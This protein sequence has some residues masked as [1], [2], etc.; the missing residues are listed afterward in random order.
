MGESTALLIP[1]EGQIVRDPISKDPL[2]VAG[3]VKPLIG[4][5]GRYWRR[6]L[7]DGSV[8]IAQPRVAKK[9]RE[10]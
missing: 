6:R 9:T 2:P 10:E 8:T 3:Q 5:E 4:P 1:A 7:R